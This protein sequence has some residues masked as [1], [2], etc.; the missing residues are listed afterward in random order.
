M[1]IVPKIL[2]ILFAVFMV[3]SALA[4]LKR[5]MSESSA[6]EAGEAEQLPEATPGARIAEIDLD[7]Y[8][9]LL[10]AKQKELKEVESRIKA[11]RATGADAP[12]KLLRS[13]DRLR[14]DVCNARKKC[15]KAEAAL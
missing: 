9:E 11:V 15:I 7:Y 10:I 5:E 4:M 6:V 13:A 3:K 1:M 14:R 8:T 12:D 2:T